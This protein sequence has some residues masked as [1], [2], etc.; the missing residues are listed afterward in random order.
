MVHAQVTQVVHSQ[1]NVVER[2]CKSESSA[3]VL[4]SDVKE[5]G[6]RS[7]LVFLNSFHSSTTIWLA[8]KNFNNYQLSYEQITEK[9]ITNKIQDQENEFLLR[10]Q[11]SFPKNIFN[12]TLIKSF[13]EPYISP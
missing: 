3:S 6:H 2:V 13:I 5:L 8:G 12:K 11:I 9:L 1:F 4:H 10:I 7:L